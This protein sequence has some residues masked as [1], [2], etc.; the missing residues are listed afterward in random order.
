VDGSVLDRL[1]WDPWDR[2]PRVPSLMYRAWDVSRI[3]TVD[4]SVLDRLTWDPWDRSPPTEPLVDVSGPAN[5][6]GAGHAVGQV[7]RFRIALA[8]STSRASC[9]IKHTAGLY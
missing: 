6:N 8:A 5:V 9:E 4:G 3:P 2:T 7:I 1:T